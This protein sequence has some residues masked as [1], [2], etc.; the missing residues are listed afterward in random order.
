M[1]FIN[2]ALMPLIALQ[3]PG[4]ARETIEFTKDPL[5]VVKK[6]VAA[7][8]AVLVDVRSQ[9]EWQKGHVD[10]SIFLPVTSL[11]KHK[12]DPEKLA[13]ALPKKNIIYTFCVVGMRAKQAGL[14]LEKQGYKV[15]VLKPGYEQLIEAGFKKGET[16]KADED[17]R[18]RNAG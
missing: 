9:E 10:G 5:E 12:L 14:I 8:K 18:Q 2:C 11:R 16:K 4:A 13:K 3:A 1:S 7:K 6:N 17:T 15:R